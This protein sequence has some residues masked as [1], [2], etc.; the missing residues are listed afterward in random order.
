MGGRLCPSYYCQPPQIQNAIYTSDSTITAR[1]VLEFNVSF[2]MSW[3]SWTIKSN[4]LKKPTIFF[5]KFLP[6][7]VF[8]VYC[9]HQ[10]QFSIKA[11]VFFQ[12]ATLASTMGINKE[13]KALL[14]TQLQLNGM[15]QFITEF[16]TKKSSLSEHLLPP[17][18]KF[19]V[20]FLSYFFIY[21]FWVLRS[22]VIFCF[23]NMQES[24][25]KGI[26]RT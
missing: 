10:K 26:L 6:F 17:P 15:R 14:V 11:N 7:Y 23:V 2:E 1:M 3:R 9:N 25:E 12:I 20:L 24:I 18:I 19:H 4:F 22:E 8:G 5:Y 13:I 21:F 16:L